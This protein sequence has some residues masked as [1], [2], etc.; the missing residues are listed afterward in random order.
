M[1]APAWAVPADG[2][3]PPAGAGDVGLVGSVAATLRSLSLPL[4][5]LLVVGGVAWFLTQS[6]R[7]SGR[8]YA[9]ILVGLGDTLP[10]RSRPGQT[11]EII[12]RYEGSA[13]QIE[14]IGTSRKVDGTVWVP[15]S[16]PGGQGWVDEAYLTEDV[17]RV[18]F[19]QD[20]QTEEMVRTL[21]AKL[22][23]GATLST[24]PR[25]T[26]D[27]ESF[28]RDEGRRE[29]GRHA[30]EKLAELIGDWRATF[31]IDK[32]ASLAALRPPQL[33]NL[34]WISFE[35]PGLAPWQLFFEYCDG[36]AHPV[37]ALPER[38]PVDI[39]SLR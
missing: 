18:S 32:T 25:G 10:V 26:I 30:T 16:S 11:G 38:V 8:R 21:R 36:G 24:S 35:A 22:K 7:K 34:H 5:T 17:A 9:V 4:L 6:G 15:I 33:R 3:V 13:R 2:L 39:A 20:V 31:H 12:H 14:S 27:P 19:E 23:D 37:A 28:Q 1:T 29:L